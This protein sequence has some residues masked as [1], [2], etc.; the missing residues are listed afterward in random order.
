MPHLLIY[1][2]LDFGLF[3]GLFGVFLVLLFTIEVKWK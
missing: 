3:P 2:A 1:N